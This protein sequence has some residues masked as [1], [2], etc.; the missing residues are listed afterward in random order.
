MCSEPR[1]SWLKV[2]VQKAFLECMLTV[3][4]VGVRV[5]RVGGGVMGLVWESFIV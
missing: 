3:M 2:R 5:T 1:G 4:N